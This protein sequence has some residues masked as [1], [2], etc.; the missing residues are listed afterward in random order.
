MRKARGIEFVKQR[1]KDALQH[2]KDF[3][4]T[5][6]AWMIGIKPLTRRMSYP[7]V[8]IHCSKVMAKS[9]EIELVQGD[10][11]QDGCSW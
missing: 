7:D 3:Q 5:H 10:V 4:S 9:K 2:I 8:R 11:C 6:A 1:H